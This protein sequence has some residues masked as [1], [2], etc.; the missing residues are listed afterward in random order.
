[1]TEDQRIEA[2]VYAF[3][4]DRRHLDYIKTD[5][6]YDL[7][8]EWLEQEGLEISATSLHAAYETLHDE[9]DVHKPVPPP[10]PTQPSEPI[11]RPALIPPVPQGEPES[12]RLHPVERRPGESSWMAARRAFAEQEIAAQRK[13][14][15][16]MRAAMQA[17]PPRRDQSRE[18]NNLF[19][20]AR[21]PRGRVRQL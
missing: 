15:Q 2:E 21:K 10:V 7:I 19:A 9:L 5:R 20:A 4:V 17:Q 11:P 12:E 13:A 18:I 1:M 6:N 16:Q 14:R 3:L 8:I